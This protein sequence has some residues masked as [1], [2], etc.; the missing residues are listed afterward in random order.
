MSYWT[1]CKTD[2]FAETVNGF[3]DLL[4]ESASDAE[5]DPEYSIANLACLDDLI[6]DAVDEGAS[7]ADVR[8]IACAARSLV[9]LERQAPKPT[10][11]ASVA[12]LFRF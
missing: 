7:F 1:D 3:A 11:A 12:S 4:R 2:D 5:L 9:R 6:Q 8:I 10:V